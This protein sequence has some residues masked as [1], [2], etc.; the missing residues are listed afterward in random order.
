VFRVSV[1]QN[2]DALRFVGE[3]SS[4]KQQVTGRSSDMRFC[5]TDCV[6]FQTGCVLGS[7]AWIRQSVQDLDAPR[8]AA[9]AS[10]TRWR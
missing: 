1:D 4:P 7:V 10:L 5:P 8:I 2:D 9:R 6:S 3:P